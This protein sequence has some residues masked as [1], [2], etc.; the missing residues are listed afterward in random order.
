MD[1]TQ[2]ALLKMV[3]EHPTCYEDRKQLRAF[4]LDYIPKNKLQQNLILNAFDEEIVE[5]LKSTSDVT[6]YA[7]RMIKDLSDGYGL[8]KEAATWSVVAWCN[9]LG[10][11]DIAEVISSTLPTDNESDCVGGTAQTTQ[12]KTPKAERQKL[13]QNAMY[14]AGSECPCGNV[15]LETIEDVEAFWYIYK[16]GENDSSDM[17]GFQKQAYITVPKGMLLQVDE[18]VYISNV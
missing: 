15:K 14:I 17:G 10:L 5:K 13:Q 1:D 3:K 12:P 7:L 11:S 4:L 6:L 8:T 16:V 9:I 18:D 2:K